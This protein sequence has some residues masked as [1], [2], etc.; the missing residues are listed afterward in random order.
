MLVSIPCVW[1]IG[2]WLRREAKIDHYLLYSCLEL[3][4]L[5]DYARQ[6]PEPCPT[7]FPGFR[8][9]CQYL[10]PRRKPALK[11]CKSRYQSE[12][13]NVKAL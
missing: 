5:L 7:C 8:M 3:A 12:L 11:R 1:P 4:D 2:K 10:N 6:F 13:E 9:A